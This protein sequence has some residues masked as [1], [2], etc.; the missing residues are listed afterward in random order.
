MSIEKQWTKSSSYK[1][2][3]ECCPWVHWKQF[4]P[5]WIVIYDDEHWNW[6]ATQV[7]WD[8]FLKRCSSW[9]SLH[10]NLQLKLVCQIWHARKQHSQQYCYKFY[11]VD[12]CYFVSITQPFFNVSMNKINILWKCFLKVSQLF[13]ELQKKASRGLF[14]HSVISKLLYM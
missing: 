2:H 13:H 5:S 9:N 14:S 12:L 10:S 8:I 1:S 11:T 4:Y 3:W 6:I 7:I